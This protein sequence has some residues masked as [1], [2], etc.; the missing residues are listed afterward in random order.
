MPRG[1]PGGFEVERIDGFDSERDLLVVAGDANDEG[2]VTR[3][4]R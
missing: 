3:R 2:R 1:L 4:R